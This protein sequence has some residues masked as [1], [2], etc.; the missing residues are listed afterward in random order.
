MPGKDFFLPNLRNYMQN[1]QPTLVSRP[2]RSNVLSIKNFLT[3]LTYVFVRQGCVRRPLQQPCDAPF[4]I[5]S[6]NNKLFTLLIKGKKSVIPVD[7]L[8][9]ALWRSRIQYSST[10]D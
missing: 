10:P 2:S 3:V 1:L 4:E 8:K 7:R 9:P 6:H 5:I